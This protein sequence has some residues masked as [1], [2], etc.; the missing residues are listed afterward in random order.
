MQRSSVQ[1]VVQ[2]QISTGIDIVNDG[3]FGKPVQSAVDYG[4]WVL[5]MASRMSGFDIRCRVHPTIAWA[6]LKTLA[7]GA[8]LASRKLWG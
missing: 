4:V 8:A 2:R 3:E 5:Y 1:E 7:D 6:K